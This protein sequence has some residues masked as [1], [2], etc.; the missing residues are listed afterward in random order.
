MS[1]EY[2]DLTPTSRLSIEPDP[3]PLDPRKD[4]CVTGCYTPPSWWGHPTYGP[5][6]RWDFP[7]NLVEA[8]NRLYDRTSWEPDRGVGRWAWTFYGVLVE[9]HGSTYWYCDRTA[10]DN[11]V[12]GEFT[13]EMQHDIITA[14]RLAYEKFLNGEARI[15]TLQRKATF[16]RITRRYHEK[17][18]DLL[19]VWEDIASIGDIYLDDRDGPAQVALDYFPLR[20]KELTVVHAM[21][22]S[23]QKGPFT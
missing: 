22:D 6:P 2:I 20:K 15:I 14:D 8:D 13:R 12:G 4:E 23:T 10:F 3:V 17:H 1:V 21:I 5:E 11:M 16:K 18:E 7:G 9:R 19:E